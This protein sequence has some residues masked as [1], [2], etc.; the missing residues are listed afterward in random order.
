[1]KWTVTVCSKRHHIRFFPK[2][3]DSAA[4][5]R[6]GNALPG[7][8]VERD[9]THPFEYDFCKWLIFRLMAN[10]DFS[11]FVLSFGNP[12]HCTTNSLSCYQG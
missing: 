7:T 6:N 1:M 11:R 4:G 2:D 8:L 10:T 5:D 12:G 3:N 9:V